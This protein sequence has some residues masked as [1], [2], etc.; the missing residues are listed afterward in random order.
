MKEQRVLTPFKSNVNDNKEK[1]AIF[2]RR[3]KD[4]T[5]STLPSVF[6]LG[7]PCTSRSHNSQ[8]HRLF[9]STP[10][11]RWTLDAR[12]L[13]SIRTIRGIRANLNENFFI[14]ESRVSRFAFTIFMAHSECCER[15]TAYCTQHSSWILKDW[16]PE[17]NSLARRR[18]D[19]PLVVRRC[20]V[21][22]NK[23]GSVFTFTIARATG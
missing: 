17:A 13:P 5:S 14:Q 2:Y 10:L 1:N 9:D 11:A 23:S 22:S 12:N 19:R 3:L 6:D 15:R 7:V 4:L 21:I 8:P 20:F 18:P 16:C